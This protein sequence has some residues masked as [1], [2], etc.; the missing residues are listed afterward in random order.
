MIRLE[1]LAAGEPNDHT[2]ETIAETTREEMRRYLAP[3][4]KEG[5]LEPP[6]GQTDEMLGRC[7]ECGMLVGRDGRCIVKLWN[8]WCADLEIYMPWADTGVSCLWQD[9]TGKCQWSRS[10]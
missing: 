9:P 7:L 8:P 3:L 4:L 5:V 2:Q 10:W 1:R 6:E